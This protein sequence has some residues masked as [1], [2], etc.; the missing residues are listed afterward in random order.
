VIYSCL[1][2]VFPDL[3]VAFL[4]A[5]CGWVPFWMEHMDEEWEK[6][7]FDAPSLTAKPSES[8]KCSRVYVSCEPEEQTIPYVAQWIGENNILYASDYPHWDCNFLESVST[9]INRSDVSDV[10]KRKIFFDNP[11]RYY[12]LK[13]R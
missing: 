11:Q 10:L 9:L 6:R 4:E 3:R 2:E 5:G 7:K 13:D 8:M 12:A 1:L